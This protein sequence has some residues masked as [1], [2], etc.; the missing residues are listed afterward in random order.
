[1]PSPPDPAAVSATYST[2]QLS[3]C[4][5]LILGSSAWSQA[6]SSFPLL[7]FGMEDTPFSFYFG[8]SFCISFSSFPLTPLQGFSK[9]P[10]LPLQGW[11]VLCNLPCTPRHFPSIS[12]L[13]MA[14]SCCKAASRFGLQPLPQLSFYPPLM[15][16]DNG[17]ILVGTSSP[18]AAHT[19]ISLCLV[20]GMQS[21]VFLPKPEYLCVHPH[22][23]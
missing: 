4:L 21:Q 22:L 14:V 16:R 19:I 2:S 3:P 23:I 12:S 5:K 13:L 9:P 1:M 17:S 10:A 20:L 6:L 11:C 7:V 18:L 15:H 8:F